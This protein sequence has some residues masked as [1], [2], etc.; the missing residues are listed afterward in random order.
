MSI[1]ICTQNWCSLCMDDIAHKCHVL[2]F[3]N[4]VQFLK[5]ITQFF[6]GRRGTPLLG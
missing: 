1:V 5:K 2:H 6:F 4:Y 3:G